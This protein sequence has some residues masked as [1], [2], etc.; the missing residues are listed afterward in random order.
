MYVQMIGHKKRSNVES[1]FVRC[2]CG[3]EIVEFVKDESEELDLYINTHCYY[4]RKVGMFSDF[5]FNGSSGL[6]IFI[7]H[8]S[9]FVR[10]DAIPEQSTQIPDKANDKK[11]QYYLDLDNDGY[12]FTFGLHNMHRKKGNNC[13]WEVIINKKNAEELLEELLRWMPMKKN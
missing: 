12:F 11:Y 5:T 13:V 1:F 10:N 3:Q 8:L 4:N 7:T 2:D 9:L 6:E